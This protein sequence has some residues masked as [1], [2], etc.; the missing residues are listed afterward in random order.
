[1]RYKDLRYKVVTQFILNRVLRSSSICIADFLRSMSDAKMKKAVAVCLLGLVLVTAVAQLFTS[2]LVQAQSAGCTDQALAL[3]EGQIT[4]TL[5]YT[6]TTQ[7]PEETIAANANK[8]KLDGASHW[9]SGFFPGEL[10]FLYEK[11]LSGSWFTRAQAQTANMQSEDIDASDHDI[12]FKMLGSYG[13][14]YRITRDP[15]YL[16]IIQTAANAMATNLWRPG[17]GVI[18]SWPN[19]DSHITV[20]IDNMMNLELLFF[21]AQNGGDAN[22]YNMAVSH[23]L[24]TME[25]HVRADGST[26]HVVDYNSDG[27][28]FSKFTVQGA[29]TETTWSRGQA[30]AIYGFTMTYRYTRDSRFLSTA[31][32]LADYFIN[33]LPPDFVPYWDFSKCCTDPRDSSAAAIAAAGLLELSTY[34]AAQADQ[35]RYRNAALNIQSSLSSPAYL[36]D[37]LATDGILLH[38]SANVPG[39]DADTS[40]IYG[41]YYFMQSCFRATPPPVAPVNLVATRTSD[42]AVILSWTPSSAA[43]AVRYNVKRNS[44]SGGPYSLLAPPPILT[45]N[46]YSDRGVLSDAPYYYVVS[47]TGIGGEGPNSTEAFAASNPDPVVSG[48]LPA[49]VTAGSGFMLTVTGGNFV[50]ASVVNLAGKPEPTSY[51]SS[52]QLTAAIPASDIASGSAASITVS[53]PGANAASAAVQ[54]AIDDFSVSLPATASVSAGSSVQVPITITPSRAEGFGSSIGFSIAG[55]PSTATARFNPP[56]V[57]PGTGTASTMLVISAAAQSEVMTRLWEA[58]VS[59]PPYWNLVWALVFVNGFLLTLHPQH[60]K[61]LRLAPFVSCAFVVL[62]LVVAWG[63]GGGGNPSSSAPKTPPPQVAQITVTATS[64]TDTKTGMFSLTL[65]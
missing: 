24:K 49:S 10:W 36:G 9:T 63:C 59:H 22:W 8:W 27:T 62:G 7:F 23:A 29:G 6:S 45:G 42:T 18:E 5:A 20:I 13:N 14:A 16:N 25:N 31:Q 57:T 26:Y 43:A 65:K 3:A 47:A 53:T 60:R 44:T 15:A 30:W 17:A 28:V 40:L 34:V 39:G 12:G 58:P 41:D 64:G 11:D 46:G 2:R 51:I 4:D 21:A 56:T 35:D 33:N 48:V 52:T 37:R 61:R 54:L 32:Q 1:V 38:G 50:P 55:L 19:Y